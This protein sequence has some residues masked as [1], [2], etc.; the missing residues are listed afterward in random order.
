M[1]ESVDPFHGAF[2]GPN[3]D[4]T[5]SLSSFDVVAYKLL[6]QH[7]ETGCG[8]L[9]RRPVPSSLTCSAL[10]HHAVHGQKAIQYP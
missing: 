2:L 4:L 7:P 6:P 3:Q 8:Y 5:R 1:I 9:N 10:P